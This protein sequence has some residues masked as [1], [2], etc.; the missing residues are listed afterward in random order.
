[1]RFCFEEDLY[2]REGLG[3]SSDE[4]PSRDTGEIGCD[5]VSD[6][7]DRPS[8]EDECST[9]H[10]SRDPDREEHRSLDHE[11]DGYDEDRHDRDED[12]EG[13]DHEKW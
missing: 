3:S 11:K 9:E 8:S 13:D 10:P 7:S 6:E 5:P 4:E 12:I 2:R 1:M